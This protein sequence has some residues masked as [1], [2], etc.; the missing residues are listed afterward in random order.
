MHWRIKGP[1]QLLA[2]RSWGHFCFSFSHS[3]G[4]FTLFFFAEIRGLLQHLKCSWVSFNSFWICTLESYH[5]VFALIS[6]L[7]GETISPLKL[8]CNISQIMSEAFHVFGYFCSFHFWVPN[9]LC[10]STSWTFQVCH[11]FAFHF[12]WWFFLPAGVFYSSL[13]GVM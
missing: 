8:S 4:P 12:K 11:S 6:L 7:P 3:H 2:E 10:L 9:F 1:A 5:M 13:M